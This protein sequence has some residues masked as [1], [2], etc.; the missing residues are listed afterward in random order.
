MP[1]QET[2]FPAEDWD[3]FQSFSETQ[4]VIDSSIIRENIEDGQV[5]S[6]SGA[7]EEH[8]SEQKRIIQKENL[9][10]DDLNKF[11]EDGSHKDD[12]EF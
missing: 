9:Q 3:D 12:G 4:L 10:E 6:L 11:S 1:K 2:G 7:L 5:N 8:L